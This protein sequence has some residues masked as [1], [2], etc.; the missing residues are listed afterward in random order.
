MN[1]TDMTKHLKNGMMPRNMHRRTAPQQSQRVQLQIDRERNKPLA[2]QC[3]GT[4]FIPSLQLYDISPLDPQNPTGQ[5]LRVSAN[6]LSCA[7]CHEPFQA[8]ATK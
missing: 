1:P 8:E 4:T 2:C 3:G 7:K 6:V 5:T